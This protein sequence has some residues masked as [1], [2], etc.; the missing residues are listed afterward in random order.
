MRRYYD[1]R[2][3]EYEQIYYRDN[4]D[5]RQEIDDEAD[6]LRE[7]ARGQD[8]IDIACGTG[9]WTTRVSDTSARIT[10]VDRSIAMIR[11]AQQKQYRCPANFVQADLNRLPFRDNSF[12]LTC[13]GFWFSHHPR[14]EYD[15]LF[16]L[17]E[18][19]TSDGGRIWMVD[20]NPP[21]EG[22]ALLQ[23]SGV[24]EHGNNYKRRFLDNGTEFVIL[25]NY[26]EADELRWILSGRF[27]I[28]RLTYKQYY[29]AVVLAAK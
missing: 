20:N 4:R 22:G 6:R 27:K 14:Q 9:Y 11:E 3:S 15:Q 28:E 29:W 16:D 2:A 7:L 12:S 21:A 8:V 19:L 17:V 25:K 5:R 26:F 13:L 10:A 23:S 18:R 24:D 1:L